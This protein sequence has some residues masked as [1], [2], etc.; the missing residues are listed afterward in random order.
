[1][2]ATISREIGRGQ[3]IAKQKT[4]ERDDSRHTF[5]VSVS[6]SISI[7]LSQIGIAKNS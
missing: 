4:K 5:S 2:H 1:M 6:V 3:V 7:F